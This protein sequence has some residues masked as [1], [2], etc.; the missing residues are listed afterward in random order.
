M[1]EKRVSAGG[2]TPDCF[3]TFTRPA[4]T[5]AYA[6]GDIVANSTTGA[7]VVPLRFPA[8]RV[9]NGSGVITGA[10]MLKS[11]DDL[12]NASFR[13]WVFA[14][15]PFAAAGY[16]ADNA[17]L[18]LTYAALQS[19]VGYFDFTSFVDAGS[20]NVAVAN[21]SRNIAPF[22]CARSQRMPTSD[23]ITVGGVTYDGTQLLYGVLEA[24]AAYTPGNAEQFTV[25]LDVQQD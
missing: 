5:T 10:R 21:P 4:D 24:R 20:A 11:D 7:S 14:N 13:L 9:P 12:V 15:Q 18:T 19:F 22:S 6:A 17:A 2:F 1:T 8:L 3:A 16:P 25:W 23:T